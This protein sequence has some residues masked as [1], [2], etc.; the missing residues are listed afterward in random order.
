MEWK[1]YQEIIKPIQ[2]F[3]KL[4]SQTVY[5]K[6]FDDLLCRYGHYFLF[7]LIALIIFFIFKDFIFLKKIYLFKDFGS[8]SINFFYPMY[9]SW[10]DYVAKEGIPRWSF[11]QGMGQNPSWTYRPFL[12]IDNIDRGKLCIL[13]HLLRRII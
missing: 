1:R 12:I 9:Y 6:S 10:A 8:D 13:H 11:N 7:S 2:I 5:F 3:N 4:K